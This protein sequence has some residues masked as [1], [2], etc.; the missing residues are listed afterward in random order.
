M[1]EEKVKK[2]RG[3]PKFIPVENPAYASIIVPEKPRA[4]MTIPD[5]EIADELERHFGLLYPVC[6]ALGVDRSCLKQRISKTPELF[7][8]M[9]EL[10]EANVDLAE[11]KLMQLV[12]QG[13]FPAI[14]LMLRSIGK[15]RGY[16]E[17]LEIKT[18]NINA[19]MDLSKLSNEELDFLEGIYK[20]SKRGENDSLPDSIIDIDSE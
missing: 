1:E 8:L 20:K 14:N 15:A 17:S 19:N 13:H 3:R 2:K 4:L 11:N 5:D 16:S 12:E 9:E 10:R 7:E 6:K 18:Q